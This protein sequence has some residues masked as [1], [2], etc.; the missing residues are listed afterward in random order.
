MAPKEK[1]RGLGRCRINAVNDHQA[2]QAWLK[3]RALN[4]HTDRAFR[5]EPERLLIWSVVERG[6][7]LSSLYSG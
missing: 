5:R 6:R 1:N 4:P 2:I 7:A 3:A